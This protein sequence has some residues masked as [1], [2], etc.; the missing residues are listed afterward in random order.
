M[1]LIRGSLL[2]HPSSSLCISVETIS[3]PLSV[4]IEAHLEP[5]LVVQGLKQRFDT[6]QP[7]VL[8]LNPGLE[9]QI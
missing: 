1:T 2:F 3:W 9:I 7:I 5:W 8:R 6:A 4:G